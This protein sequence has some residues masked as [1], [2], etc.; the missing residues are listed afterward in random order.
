MHFA[1]DNTINSEKAYYKKFSSAKEDK[2]TLISKQEPIECADVPTPAC[3][4]S[5]I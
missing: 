3:S 5:S 1:G 2:C 4:G